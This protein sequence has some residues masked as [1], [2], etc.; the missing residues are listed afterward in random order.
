MKKYADFTRGPIL[1][2]LVRFAL[3]VLLALFLQAMYGAVDLQVVGKFGSAA[4]ISAVSTGSQL[5]H[6][7]TVVITG[8]TMGITILVGQRLGEGRPDRAGEA[9]GGGIWLFAVVA[10]VL[11]GVL[12]ALAAPLAAMMQAPEAA[13]GQ[14]VTYVR[15]CSGGMV[16]I[17]AYN[18]LGGIFRGIGDSRMPL[19]TVSIACG[20]NIA[21]DLLLVGGLR[22][23]VAGAAIAT[24]FAQAVSVLLSLVII[25]RR[26]LPFT[27][28]RRQ[29]RFSRPTVGRILLLGSP[30]AFQDLLVSISFLVLIA[31]ANSLGVV[32]SAGV[33]IAE[34]ICA[35]IMLVPSAYM[36]SISAFV[37]QNIGAG[38]P[39]RARRAL[40]CSVLTS[41]AAGILMAW[42]TFFHGDLM[43]SIF[44]QA[45][46]REVILAAADYLK[47]Y[48]LDCLL[49]CFLF[50]FTGYFNG[51]GR[52]LF[53]MVQGVVGAF[54]VRLPVAYLVSR[55]AEVS[56]FH[57]GL[58]TPASTVVQILLCLGFF[59]L[60][61]RRERR[62]A[63]GSRP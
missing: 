3:P 35:F 46:D 59:L 12:L 44:A 58:A 20:L 36:Q 31:I 27:L 43:A 19:I 55:G 39:E 53:V 17:V 40:L 28:T 9:V 37:A 34:K 32:A 56:L 24:V 50:C 26:Q 7:V 47:A 33:G 1:L 25:R 41:L 11:T 15:I 48:A 62:L 30:I 51:C 5:M 49:T 21:G 23:G 6:S 4:D 52:T 60:L 63:G 45:E 8:L 22:L 38:R 10:V 16:F 42:L 13:F 61:R 14:T 2:P 29:I 57:L 54:G 18:V